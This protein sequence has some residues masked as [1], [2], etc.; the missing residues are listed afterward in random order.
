[1]SLSVQPSPTHR[2]TCGDSAEQNRNV[3]TF[4]SFIKR[5]GQNHTSENGT[6]RY[7]DTIIGCCFSNPLKENL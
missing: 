6:D 3:S 1:M 4:I 5:N 7:S 2:N